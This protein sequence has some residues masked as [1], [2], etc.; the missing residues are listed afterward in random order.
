MLKQLNFNIEEMNQNDGSVAYHRDGDLVYGLTN[1]QHALWQSIP[2]EEPLLVFYC[3]Q[4]EP[5]IYQ[6]G[7]NFEYEISNHTEVEAYGSYHQLD[8]Q[9]IP[10]ESYDFNSI[11][12][13]I[14]PYGVADN[15][16]Q[17]KE[18]AKDILA[19]D[20]PVVISVTEMKKT[21]QPEE[22][23]WRW[24]KWG[25]YIGTQ[26]PQCDYLHDEPNID[27]VYVFHVY[28]VRPK[29]EK[30]LSIDTKDSKKMKM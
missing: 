15:V 8:K 14:S 22:D 23:G 4:I 24:E 27:S 12:E 6:T 16:A 30:T 25:Q 3:K 5:G 20:N 21:Q 7:L 13:G 2:H 1:P 17:I 18:Y 9:G 29:M 28:A 26:N 11:R 19:S 10:I